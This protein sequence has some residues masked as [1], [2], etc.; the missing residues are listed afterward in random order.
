[1]DEYPDLA[2]HVLQHLEGPG[3]LDEGDFEFALDLILDGVERLQD[4]AAV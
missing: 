1:V 3:H 2:E 4:A